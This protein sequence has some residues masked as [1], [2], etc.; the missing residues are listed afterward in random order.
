MKD[1]KRKKVEDQGEEALFWMQFVDVHGTDYWYNFKTDRM[2]Y[3]MPDVL[4]EMDEAAIMI[5]SV[6]RGKQW[7]QVAS[8]MRGNKQW[9]FKNAAATDIQRRFRGFKTRRLLERDR[10]FCGVGS[11]AGDRDVFPVA[12]SEDEFAFPSK[13]L[14]FKG[15]ACASNRVNDKD[16]RASLA[17]FQSENSFL[18]RQATDGTPEVVSS[19]IQQ[20][21]ASR[22]SSEQPA[23]LHS[24]AG[25]GD[26]AMPILFGPTRQCRLC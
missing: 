10:D 18:R 12:R 1:S 26:A 2:T 3:Y 9:A 19:P 5:Q 25:D 14:W 11:C 4:S 23:T 20:Q 7:R 17:T 8:A 6:W 13:L 21:I 22:D 16:D 24:D 15:T